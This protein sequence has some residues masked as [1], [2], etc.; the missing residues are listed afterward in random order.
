MNDGQWFYVDGDTRQGPLTAAELQ[1]LLEADRITLETPV[2][3]K[4]MDGRAPIAAI[5]ELK[6]AMSASTAPLGPDGQWQPA[7]PD[8]AQPRKAGAWSRFLARQTDLVVFSFLGGLPIAIF[9]PALLDWKPLSYGFV[10]VFFSILLALLL[11]IPLMA[12]TGTTFGKWMFGLS[13]RRS[14]GSKIGLLGLT[15]RNFLLWIYG[16]GLGLPLVILIRLCLSY[17]KAATGQRCPWDE[18]PLYLVRQKPI[19]KLRWGLGLVIL[20]S[21][22][23]LIQFADKMDEE[24]WANLFHD[25]ITWTNPVTGIATPDKLPAG[26][27]VDEDMGQPDLYGFEGLYS[28]IT[29]RR[30]ISPAANLT[31][32]LAT[33]RTSYDFGAYQGERAGVTTNRHPTAS[34]LFVEEMESGPFD[35][36]VRA[37]RSG[38][39]DFWRMIIYRPTGNE[40]ARREAQAAI[41][42]LE[43]TVR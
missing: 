15:R 21:L 30:E 23:G 33:L 2:W 12:A 13:V 29:F 27:I 1:A 19:G 42:L 18:R 31:D 14:D 40:M 11:E 38:P 28:F 20:L 10:D 8:D 37:W 35:V 22:L 43:G 4:G 24:A 16:W 26:W 39:T 41:N 5:Y 34:L 32:Y 9:Y 17:G 36:E 3:R 25:R 6:I 7:P